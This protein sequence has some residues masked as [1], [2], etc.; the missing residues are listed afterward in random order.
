MPENEG[1]NP[2]KPE[3]PSM[4]KRLLLAFVLMGAVL[5]LTPYFYK[6]FVPPA[7]K[8][9]APVATAKAKPEATPVPAPETQAATI[10][11]P[12]A[13]SPVAGDKEQSTL[14]D[15][16]LYRIVFSNHGATVRSWTLKKFKDQKGKPLELVNLAAVAKA[17]FPFSIGFK[18]KKPTA[19]INNALFAAK[20][21]SDG[22]GVSYEFSDGKTTARKSFRF[23]KDSY[24]SQFS[25]E[26]SLDSAGLAH[27][28]VW[29]GGFG[30]E[31]VQNAAANQHT[32]HYDAAAGKLIVKDVKAAKNGPVTDYGSFSFAGLEDNYFATVFLPGSNAPL[33]VRTLSDVVSRPSEPKEEPHV[34]I[35][36][37]G[38]PVNQFTVFAGPKDVDILKKVD[39]KLEQVVDWGW[40]GLIAKPLFLMLNWLND[41]VVHNYGWAIVLLTILINFAL[42]PLKFSSMKSMKKMQSLQPQIATINEKYKGIG[43]RDPKKAQQ[44]QETMELYKK[45]GVNPMGGC[46]PMVLQ[47]PFFFAFYKVLM[48]SVEMRG[49]SWLWVSDLSQPEQLAIR[50]LP[51]TMIITQFIQQKMTPTTTADPN[52]QRMMMLMP[53]VFGF[54]FYHFSSGLVLYWLTSN[55]VGIAQQWFINRTVQVPILPAP[56]QGKR[57]KSSGG[58]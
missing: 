47:I 57:K 32:L 56:D 46:L 43:I 27:Y 7:P 35:E 9:T 31:A 38:A 6:T 22:L 15:T 10:T 14:I 17:G 41:H 55:V 44:N 18:D 8:S 23:K 58:K 2:I 3:G 1:Q 50:I 53:L 54:M 4:E 12:A 33:E 40:F 29:R 21:D 11:A 30:D 25:S 13:S 26:V 36:I 45:H 24:S 52:Q 37:G 5:F 34:G 48:V 51:I 49:A 19:D 20:P 16:D 28:L 42:L 39:P